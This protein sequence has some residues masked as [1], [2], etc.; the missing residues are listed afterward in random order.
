VQFSVK[1]TRATRATRSMMYLWTAEVPTDGQGFR[2]IGTGSPGT[3]VI[4]PSVAQSF[5]AVLAIH[6]TAL[7]ANGKAYAADRVYELAK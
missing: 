5:P 6:L 1:L 3:F 7:N 4:P 2:V